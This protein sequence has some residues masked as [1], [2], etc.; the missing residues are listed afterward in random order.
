MM[1]LDLKLIKYIAC[2]IIASLVLSSAHNTAHAA[3]SK[4]EDTAYYSKYKFIKSDNYLNIGVQ[5]FYLPG[6]VITAV[7][8]RDLILQRKLKELGITIVF[9]VFLTGRDVN[10]F[11]LSDDLQAGVAGDM[12]VITVASKKDVIIPAIMH[13]SFSSIVARRYMLTENLNGKRIGY[14]PGS[15]GNYFL[16]RTLSDE[17][18]KEKDVKL[19]PLDHTEMAA[20][21]HSKTIAAF[22][23]TEPTV[24]LAL[25]TYPDTVVI[26]R[27][28]TTGYLFLSKEYF[29]RHPEAVRQIVAAQIRAIKWIKSGRGNL[30]LATAW[31]QADVYSLS[32]DKLKITPEQIADIMI[33]HLSWQSDVPVIPEKSLNKDGQIAS[34]VGFM[35]NQGKIDSAVTTEKIIGSFDRKLIY[36]VI[37]TPDKYSLN[38]FHYDVKAVQ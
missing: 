15:T 9:Y 12:P 38:E 34:I 6:G 16:L 8:S 7:M 30:S 36:E 17:G 2:I 11:F 24:S 37:D 14:I 10:K 18:I 35:K 1:A 25:I 3:D 31:V 5:P 21:L 22:S 27:S 19:V 26:H 20:A 33:K 13:Q 29:I 28:L 32:G 4:P 23:D